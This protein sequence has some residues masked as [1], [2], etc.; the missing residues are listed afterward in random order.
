[1]S[2]R[3]VLLAVAATSALST[4]AF[5]GVT[6]NNDAGHPTTREQ[7]SVACSALENQYNRIIEGKLDSA[8]ADKAEGL[9]AR[10]VDECESNNGDIGVLKLKQAVRLLGEKPAA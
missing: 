8:V 4:A 3:T 1:M 9:H 2:L 7:A 10:G 5:A 6:N